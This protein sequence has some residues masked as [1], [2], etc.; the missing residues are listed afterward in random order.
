MSI[1]S[2][3]KKKKAKAI[4]ATYPKEEQTLKLWD[5]LTKIYTHNT[6]D[7]MMEDLGIAEDSPQLDLTMELELLYK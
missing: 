2:W 6:L 5:A 4:I 7:M 1:K 3:S